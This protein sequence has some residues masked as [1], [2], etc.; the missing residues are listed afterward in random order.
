MHDSESA[1]QDCHTCGKTQR[2]VFAYQSSATNAWS[3]YYN[4]MCYTTNV[5]INDL[6]KIDWMI[7]TKYARKCSMTHELKLVMLEASLN[8]QQSAWQT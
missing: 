5:I 3:T 1:S 4:L 6:Y 8:I 2:N 7:P